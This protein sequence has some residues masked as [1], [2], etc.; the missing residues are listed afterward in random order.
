MADFFDELGQQ[1]R[2]GLELWESPSVAL[3]V[4]YQG[5][6]VF[7]GAFGL[8]DAER[9]LPANERT[10]YQ[11]ASCT[12]AF[13]ATL[14]AMF[15]DEGL[16]DW[17]TPVREYLPEVRFYDEYATQMVSVRDLLCHRTGLPRHEYSWYGTDYT[18]D[19]IVFNL[20]YL[21]P[22]RPLRTTFQYNNQCF[23]L[24]GRVLERLSGKTF[25]ELLKERILDPLGMSRSR[26]FIDDLAEDANHAVGYGRPDGGD[27][28]HGRCAIPYYKSSVEDRAAGVGSPFAPAGCISSCVED[29][30]SWLRLHLGDKGAPRLASAGALDVLHAPQM[31][32]DSSLDMPCEEVAFHCYG[33]GWFIESYRGHKLV[34]H[35][36]NIDG[37]SSFAGMIPDLDLGV[38]ACTNMNG[39]L[40]HN[41]LAYEVF[42]HFLGVEG[43]SWI[44]RH[45]DFAQEKA[46]KNDDMVSRLT[47]ERVEGTHPSHSLEDY[48]GTYARPGYEPL[49]ISLD[50]K[51]LALDFNHWHVPLSH[52]SYDTFTLD[53]ILGELPPGIPVHFRLAEAGGAVDGVA[54]PLQTEPGTDLVRFSRVLPSRDC[55]A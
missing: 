50:D 11:I 21:E 6:T 42:D 47:G 34:E 51:T 7:A 18:R 24:A 13:T 44:K 22:N 20:R 9:E 10:L 29:M 33:L 25:E 14:A 54:V 55:H 52:F 19:D 5:E 8:R 45:H 53:D 46:E 43:G 36:G 15:V 3:G 4:T 38:F 35:S 27:P 30:L 17:D 28:L 40:L 16:L 26:F 32:L 1:A 31:L 48:V 12:K 39:S 2:E 37:Y 23:V 49:R 41:A